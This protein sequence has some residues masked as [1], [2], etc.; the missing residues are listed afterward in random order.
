MAVSVMTLISLS[1]LITGLLRFTLAQS[2]AGQG[3]LATR[4]V[5][6]LRRLPV[7]SG[8]YYRSGVALPFGAFLGKLPQAIASDLTAQVLKALSGPD[9]SYFYD[10]LTLLTKVKGSAP[11]AGTMQS[12]DCRDW[13]LALRP[14]FCPPHW[15]DWV[16]PEAFVETWLMTQAVDRSES[17]VP[18]LSLAPDTLFRWHHAHAR[19]TALLAAIAA[20]DEPQPAL[21]R[22]N[23][24][25]FWQWPGILDWVG[26]LADATDAANA[27]NAAIS[28]Q[29]GKS[30]SR[31]TTELTQAIDQ[32]HR[33]YPLQNKRHLSIMAEKENVR[34]L[35]GRSQ[36]ALHQ[37]LLDLAGQRPVAEL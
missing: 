35:G 26:A 31:A 27:A 28:A 3:F 8:L 20:S 12:Q 11:Q 21:H 32:I 15:L 6:P 2:Q 5:L 29:S 25:P 7:D 16:L 1:Q 23:G 34:L 9:N 19:C 33:T 37:A 4:P 17:A 10:S 14:Q 18:V 22:Q 24:L 30:W 36:A 13:A